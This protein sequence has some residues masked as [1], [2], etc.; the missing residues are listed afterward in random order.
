MRA[1][2]YKKAED[3]KIH[4]MYVKAYC[5]A[6]EQYYRAKNKNDKKAAL[7]KFIVAAVKAINS[8]KDPEYIDREDAE[9]EFQFMEIIQG[10][11]G[12]LTPNEFMQ[13][14]PIDKFYNGSRY[15]MKDYFSTMNYIN[16]LDRDKPIGKEILKFIWEYQNLEICNFVVE[17]MEYISR[18][19]RLDGEP[20]I[21]KE[22]ADTMGL[23]TYTMGKDN[24]GRQ[25]LIDNETGKT[26]RIR[27]PRPRY[28]KV[29]K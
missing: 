18:L 12:M 2:E 15:S 27:K 6:I 17:T 3:T 1:R 24:K 4:D 16:G 21:A 14:Y 8:K 29:V 20:S 25:Y 26:T 9:F 11:M 13:I 22:F 23:K 28:L 5:N 7:I 10:F 19:R